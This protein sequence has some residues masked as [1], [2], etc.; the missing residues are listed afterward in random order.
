MILNCAARSDCNRYVS[1]ASLA[2]A[3]EERLGRGGA[4]AAARQPG[5]RNILVK[6]VQSTTRARQLPESPAL[7]AAADAADINERTDHPEPAN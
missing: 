7:P 6:A 5:E 1:E 4:D 2:A 3:E